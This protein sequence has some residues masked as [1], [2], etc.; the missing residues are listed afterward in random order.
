MPVTRLAARDR[1]TSLSAAH[2]A[3]ARSKLAA[4]SRIPRCCSRS[5]QSLRPPSR[6]H[7][8]SRSLLP[9]ALSPPLRRRCCSR[10]LQSLRPPLR[11]HCCSRSVQSLVLSPP[12]RRNCC[13]RS[14]QSLAL[15]P[16]LRR[17]CCSCSLQSLRPP[18]RRRYCSGSVQSLALSPPL[19]RHCCSRSVQSLRPPLR[20]HCCSR[21]LQSLALSHPPRCHSRTL[22]SLAGTARH[23]SRVARRRGFAAKTAGSRCVCRVAVLAGGRVVLSGF[24]AAAPVMGGTGR[25]GPRVAVQ[26][27]ARPRPRTAGH[28]VE[29]RGAAALVASCAAPRTIRRTKSAHCKRR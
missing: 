25:S 12:L 26:V 15:S 5:L 3:G 16:P 9:L 10:S 29:G 18:L 7:C 6:S 24:R 4:H 1:V 21:S 19:R 17:R 20:R 8:C 14:V 27:T 22:P 13:S 23:S 11:K 2:E 28:V